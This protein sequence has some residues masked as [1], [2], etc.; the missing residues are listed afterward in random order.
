MMTGLWLGLAPL[1]VSCSGNLMQKPRAHKVFNYTFQE[2]LRTPSTPQLSQQLTQGQEGSSVTVRLNNQRTTSARLGK[3]YH[4]ASG[5][6][7]RRYF[8]NANDEYV[9]CLIGGRWQDAR[10]V[11][12][13]NLPRS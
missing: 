13:S 2:P 7:C 3:R 5:Y 11:I 12:V 9:A 10:P 6:Q 1:L 8:V 4:S